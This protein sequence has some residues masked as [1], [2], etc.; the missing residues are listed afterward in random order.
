MEFLVEGS[1]QTEQFALNED[2]EP[3][4]LDLITQ[5]TL[6]KSPNPLLAGNVLCLHFRVE[7][8]ETRFLKI[9]QR[10]VLLRIYLGFPEKPDETGPCFLGLQR[11][12]IW[13]HWRYLVWLYEEG[14]VNLGGGTC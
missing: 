10:R 5:D 12:V 6:C 2:E 8:Q 4:G 7:V 3:S 9:A 11:G 1:D 13:Q 14:L